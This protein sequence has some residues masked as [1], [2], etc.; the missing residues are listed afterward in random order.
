MARSS[1]GPSRSSGD[2]FGISGWW[3][4]LTLQVE[5]LF[6]P[7]ALLAFFFGHRLL[8][9]V[10]Q[11][12]RRRDRRWRFRTLQNRAFTLSIETGWVRSKPQ[13]EEAARTFNATSSKA[14][15]RLSFALS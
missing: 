6:N 3:G 8:A 9:F 1:L 10:K 11:H 15:S 7:Q 2:V 12:G 5:Y 14:D 4:P 13:E